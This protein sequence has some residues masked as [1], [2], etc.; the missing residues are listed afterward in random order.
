MI[1]DNN[2]YNNQINTF[3]LYHAQCFDGFTAAWCA[4]QKLGDEAIY[5][6]VKHGEPPPDLPDHSRVYLV[7]FAYPRPITLSLQAKSQSLI[8]LD[9]H[10][11]AQ[12]ELLGLKF[13][14][15]NMEKSGAMLA[16]EYWQGE[17]TPPDLVRYVQDRD[18]W[19]KQL[20][21]TEEIHI[22][23]TTMPQ[24]FQQWQILAEKSDF[25]DYMAKI[26]E[27]LLAKKKATIEAIA[28][29]PDWVEIAGYRVPCVHA[30]HHWSDICHLLC[31]RFPQ[32]K[33]AVSWRM[34]GA[35]KRWDLRSV[36][37]FDVSAIARL[38]GGGGHKNAAGFQGEIN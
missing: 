13:A 26:G 1:L 5:I 14:L 34:D 4:W 31:D 15:F 29:Q 23:L 19:Q 8:I 24:T 16:W 10:K 38:Y 18:L 7:D 25:V 3:V 17:K 30:P 21:F 20:P 33:F 35:I 32:A 2:L 28:R 22:A 36:D 6:P 37:D 9:H 11:T 27:P 12:E